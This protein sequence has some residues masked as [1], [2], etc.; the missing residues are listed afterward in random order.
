MDK[1]WTLE[2]LHFLQPPVLGS[3]SPFLKI[4]PTKHPE[5]TYDE[6]SSD[7]AVEDHIQELGAD[8]VPPN[9]HYPFILNLGLLRVQLGSISSQ[10]TNITGNAT[11]LTGTMKNNKLC[12]SCCREISRESWPE[13][14]FAINIRDEYRRIVEQCFRLNNLPKPLFE[15]GLDAAGRRLALRDHVVG[16]L[17]ELFRAMKGDETP[18]LQAGSKEDKVLKTDR[19]APIFVHGNQANTAA[20]IEHPIGSIV[21]LDPGCMNMFPPDLQTLKTGRDQ[22]L[23]L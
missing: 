21:L 6:G 4:V 12:I 2:T 1:E 18:V 11:A 19:Y 15:S 17:F 14:G 13:T 9:H 23:P 16:P 22:E 10:N 7:P 8:G 5:P 20:V 3:E